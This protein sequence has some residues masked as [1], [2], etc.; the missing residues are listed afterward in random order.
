MIIKTLKHFFFKSSLCSRGVK[1]VPESAVEPGV[2][3]FG[4][5]ENLQPYGPFWNK[6]DN[7]LD[8][9]DF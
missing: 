4:W 8:L 2:L 3:L 1:F 6:F 7:P 9:N 5:S